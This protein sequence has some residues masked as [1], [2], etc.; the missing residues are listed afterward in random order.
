M[1]LVFQGKAW[2]NKGAT[3]EFMVQA[4]NYFQRALAIDP[5]NI[6][7]LIGMARVHA[8][9]GASLLTDD[10]AA[11]CSAAETILIDVLS[12]APD[13]AIAHLIL[14]FCHILT[15]RASQGI[16]ECEHALALNRNL[17]GAHAAIGFGKLFLGSA[18]QTEGHI[19][20]AF[21]LSP[22]D[23]FAH[24]WMHTVGSAKI[25][26]G[27]YAEAVDWLRRSV[28]ANRNFPIAHFWLAAALGLLGAV[29]EARIAA[30]AGLALDPDFTV[31]RL[32]AGRASDNAAVLA[33]RDRIC[34]GMR[35]AGI[36]EG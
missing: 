35:L 31:R 9:R 21:R 12:R 16:S 33:A 26:L 14:G 3:P 11:C 23:I 28:E 22:R 27:L 7:A 19:L 13:H 36:P 1:D 18:A 8:G 29:D 34:E 32:R 24:R 4:T 15:S 17:A 6:E 25:Q 30:K 5:R 2:L 20:N 10:R